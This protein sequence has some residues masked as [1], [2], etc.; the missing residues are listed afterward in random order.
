MLITKYSMRQ[1][2][3]VQRFGRVSFCPELRETFPMGHFP[4]CSNGHKTSK[5]AW[6]GPVTSRCVPTSLSSALH[7]AVL[8]LLAPLLWAKVNG[9]EV[10]GT[11]S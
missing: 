9:L 5:S 4:L 11:G 7:F 8:P 2:F 1:D 6:Q 3:R 10:Y